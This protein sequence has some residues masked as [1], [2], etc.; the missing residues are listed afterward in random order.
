MAE[1][2]HKYGLKAPVADAA[3]AAQALAALQEDLKPVPSAYVPSGRYSAMG[4]LR[5]LLGAP[6]AGVAGGLAGAAAIALTLALSVGGAVVFGTSARGDPSI[7]SVQPLVALILTVV[8]LGGLVVSFVAAG[9]LTVGTL[10]ALNHGVP[11]RNRSVAGLSGGVA[12]AV[13]V[14]LLAYLLPI[15]IRR[16]WAMT[17][18]RTGDISGAVAFGWILFGVGALLV[19]LAGIGGALGQV[20]EDKFCEPCGRPMTTTAEGGVTWAGGRAIRDAAAHGP[21]GDLATMLREHAGRDVRV[22]T[23]ACPACG[24]GFVECSGHFRAAWRESGGAKHLARQWL[25]VSAAVPAGASGGA[26][27]PAQ[28]S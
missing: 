7:K 10:H 8:L 27:V 17:G 28:R 24:A 15:G 20:S 23:W 16:G 19:L 3:A 5:L 22:A 9:M 2:K 25:F 21:V 4:A 11:N 14:L 13:A 26:L 18:V 12:A 6:V 1:S